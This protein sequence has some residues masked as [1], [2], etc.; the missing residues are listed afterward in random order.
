MKSR[1]FYAPALLSRPDGAPTPDHPAT[2]RTTCRAGIDPA[3]ACGPRLD[4]GLL[5]LRI[6]LGVGTARDADP[7]LHPR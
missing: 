1:C 4:Y 3:R 2:L 7:F 5:F 6:V